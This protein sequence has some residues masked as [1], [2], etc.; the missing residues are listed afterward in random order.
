MRR[1][2]SITSTDAA[3]QIESVVSGTNGMAPRIVHL[4]TFIWR[5]SHINTVE[6][7]FSCR[8]T[9]KA[10]YLLEP[11]LIANYM[12]RSDSKQWTS[13]HFDLTP[14]L[15]FMNLLTE[16][17]E[18]LSQFGATAVWVHQNLKIC[19]DFED[20]FM[21]NNFPLDVQNLRVS[22][23]SRHNFKSL[24]LQFSDVQKSAV[25][26][27]ACNSQIFDVQSPLLIDYRDYLNVKQL[28]NEDGLLCTQIAEQPLLSL[29]SESQTGARYCRA[30]IGLVAKRHAAYYVW[31]ILTIQFLIGVSTFSIFVIDPD[32]IADRLELLIT[33]I[34]AS[35]AFKLV[36]TNAGNLA[37]T[38]PTSTWSATAPA[39]TSLSRNT[40]AVAVAVVT[41]AV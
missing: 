7:T 4:Q 29:E 28:G 31:N 35:T 12:D 11:D 1:R 9:L 15:R 34:L 5:I 39:L 17:A 30:H 26:S 8:F 24:V 38:T 14:N 10:S 32:E 33:L 13:E 6:Q 41:T 23:T 21:L 36:T 19:G 3:A 37:P 16:T 2:G 22:I 25:L 40:D 20:T 27:T 18:H